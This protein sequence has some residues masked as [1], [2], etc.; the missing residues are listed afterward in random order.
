M[1]FQA[2]LDTVK[3]KTGLGPE[4]FRALAE[5]K[6]L[7]APGVKTGQIVDWL[8]QDFDLGRG[9]A[10]AIITTFAAPKP[11]ADRIDKQFLGAKQHWRPVFEQLLVTLG[12]FGPVTTSPTDSYI[13]LVK[14]KAKFGVVAVTGDRLDIGVKLKG[15]EP[16]E[17]FEASGAWNA[18]VTHRVRI[19]DPAQL[20]AEVLDWL[21]RGYDAA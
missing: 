20:D 8:K 6:G 7:L 2:Y 5:Q 18:M 16:T 3:A 4:E 11:T 17:R 12:G 13:S 21:R 19:T 14:G 9:H 10:M 15:A 1:T